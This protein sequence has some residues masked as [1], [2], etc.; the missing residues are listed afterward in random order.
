MHTLREYIEANEDWLVKRVLFHART[1][2]YTSFTSTLEQPWRESICGFSDPILGVLAEGEVPITLSPRASHLH[3][4]SMAFAVEEARL[5]RR[6]GVPLDLYLGLT[7]YYRQ[8]YLDLIDESNFPADD[9]DRY[10]LFINRFFDNIEIVTCH[11]WVASGETARVAELTAKNRDIINE[12]NKY[13]T[14]FESLHLPVFLISDSGR[15]DNLNHAALTLFDASAVPGQGYYARSGSDLTEHQIV[16]VLAGRED[17]SEFD[18]TLET[19][20]GP[21][22]F[23]IRTQRLLDVSEK[24]MGR[25]AILSDV[26]EYKRAERDA[27]AA[28]RAKSAFLATMSHEIRTPI[29]GILGIG[30]LLKDEPSGPREARYVDALLSS[31]E[32]L[33]DLVNDVLD[34]SKL[35]SGTVTLEPS[36]FA[37]RAL[38][39]RISLMTGA[40]LERKGLR[41]RLEIADDVP[42]EVVGDR[43]KIQRILLNLIDNAIK[44]T[45]AGSVTVAVAP[46]G[47]WLRFSV[48]DT[49]P[50]IAQ[51]DKPLLFKPFVRHVQAGGRQH[52]GT[53]LGLAISSRLAEA[54]GGTLGVESGKGAGTRFWL[55]CPPMAVAAPAAAPAEADE[56]V[57]IDPLDVLLVEDNEVNALVIEGFLA[58]DG[59]RTKTVGTG[60][61]ALAALECGRHDIVLLDVRMRGMG[62]VEAIRRIRTHADPAVADLPVLIITADSA[63]PAVRSLH[64][65]GAGWIL[66]KPFGP[67]ALRAA[68]AR[69]LGTRAG[70]TRAAATAGQTEAPVLD[71]SVLAQHAAALGEG[72]ADK[73]AK[74]FL[75][76]APGQA[77]AAR[78][79]ATTDDRVALGE[80]AH[81]LKSSAELVGLGRLAQRAAR[82]SSQRHG[83]GSPGENAESLAQEIEAASDA[84]SRHLRSRR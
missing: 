10:R 17:P 18:C 28:N 33:L 82:T 50:G 11:E 19:M 73:I 31:G 38:L 44:F 77:A 60:E 66:E 75:A 36:L 63:A 57:G 13:L 29:S 9:K 48:A 59:H 16:P 45:D 55:D 84:L 4:P 39:E 6:R 1:Q 83:P 72:R 65:E 64:D 54:M 52:P 51:E 26:T 34:Y 20:K 3:E 53:G 58:R 30:R 23:H 8:S 14:I 25:V 7:K 41:F 35:E 78:R 62:G 74:A 79:A 47:E 40:E 21:R 15:I 71:P 56:A 42:D 32:I 70:V 22:E 67:E 76:T 81:V 27:E 80:L 24:F 69:T 37:P 61:D 12:K 5:H 46:R 2:G 49:G 43:A 68:M